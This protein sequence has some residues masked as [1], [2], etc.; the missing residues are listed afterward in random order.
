MK[1]GSSSDWEMS[2]AGPKGRDIGLALS[3]PIGCMLAHGLNGQPE[4]N[5]S[6]ELFINSLIDS[7]LECMKDSG[8]TEDELAAILRNI[9]GWSGWFQYLAFYMLGV[10]MEFF[11]VETEEKTGRMKDA[12]GLLGLKF[13]RLSY[14][15]D[16]LPADAGID[17]IRKMFNTLLDEEVVRAQ[18]MWASFR[19][20]K[21]P[22]KSSI[23]RGTNRRVSDTTGMLMH[24]A[25]SV[26]NL[27]LSTVE[28]GK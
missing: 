28:D 19:R 7:Y 14:D 18:D 8:K 22:R 4:A 26:R 2:M 25:E 10:Q 1:R 24:A 6:I 5:E 13:L 9:I 17:E 15:T 21:Q 23:F 20:K 12:V 27:S 3:F 11:P 16:Y